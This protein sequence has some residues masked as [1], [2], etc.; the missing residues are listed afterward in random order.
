MS[1]EPRNEYD[2][3]HPHERDEFAPFPIA[4]VFDDDGR[5]LVCALAVARDQTLEADDP[6]RPVIVTAKVYEHL[7]T[8]ATGQVLSLMAVGE[9]ADLFD[10]SDLPERT[11]WSGGG[12]AT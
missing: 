8:V 10:L 3:R 11:P 2:P 5:C 7:V 1:D 4:P 12:A 6:H 9:L